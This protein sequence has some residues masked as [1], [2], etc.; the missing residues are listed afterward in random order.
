LFVGKKWQEVASSSKS[1]SSKSASSNKSAGSSN[2]GRSVPYHQHGVGRDNVFF[3]D[4]QVGHV[5]SA[6]F[7]YPFEGHGGQQ[8]RQR[9]AVVEQLNRERREAK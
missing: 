3:H 6:F 9:N 5:W 1:A 4:G 2:G 7:Q 8:Q